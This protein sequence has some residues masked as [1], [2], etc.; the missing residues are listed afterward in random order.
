MKQ[1]EDALEDYIAKTSEARLAE[2]REE[3]TL[4]R[5]DVMVL[6]ELEA[7]DNVSLI[8]RFGIEPARSGFDS[9]PLSPPLARSMI[10]LMQTQALRLQHM[11]E[12]LDRSR[13]ALEERKIIDRAKGLLMKHRKLREDEAYALL[14]KLAMDQS[15]R[16]VDVARA[17]LSMADML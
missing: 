1:V 10:E 3:L 4:Y 7:A 5:R 13:S 17:V 2:A 12:E 11:Q 9:N 16:L 6:Q 15:R 8:E 14:R